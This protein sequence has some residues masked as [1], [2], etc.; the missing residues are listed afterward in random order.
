MKAKQPADPFFIRRFPLLLWRTV[1][2]FFSDNVSRLGAA[3]AF[4][5]TV[6]IAPMLVLAIALAGFFFDSKDAARERVLMEIENLAGEQ[7]STAIE[8]VQ[9]PANN[10]AGRI[11][12]IISAGTLLFGA[13]GV[14]YHLQD[15]LNTI[16]HVPPPKE[17]SMWRTLR[18]RL[19][20][21]AM[22][23]VTGF[24]LLVSLIASAFL[25][26]LSANTVARLSLP[27]LALQLV[28]IV[29]SLG[30]VT[31]LFAVIF[32]LLPDTRV[33]WRHVWL[34]SVFTAVL[35]TAGKTGLGFYLAN[36]SVASAYGAAGSLIV[37]LLWC[38]Y[39]AQIIFFGAEFT[40]VTDLSDGGRDFSD[41]DRPVRR[42]LSL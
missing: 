10:S 22:V 12:T 21:I 18:K 5:T 27:P 33:R 19:F 34:G 17:T 38:Y 8:A 9:S 20:S 39:A 6:A 7:A 32:R 40:R 26:W 41:L 25:S 30:M 29:L 31:I 11:A 35:F 15:A 16:W 14:F 37:L 3:L 28:N 36:A 1:K 23:L 2:V 13:F 42:N 4:Y 24:L